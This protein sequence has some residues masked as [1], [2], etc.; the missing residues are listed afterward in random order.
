MVSGTDLFLSLFN[1]LAVFIVLI[2]VYGVINRHFGKSPSFTKQAAVGVCFGIFAIGCM[3]VKIPVAQGV[4]VDQRNA[5]V[6]LSGAFG[7]PF[8]AIISAV[9]AG[10][11][12]FQL[13]GMGVVGGIIGVFL[14]AGAGI[15]A[16][17]YRDKIDNIFKASLA[18]IIATVIILPGFL[19]IKDL[20]SGWELLQAMALPYGLAVFIGLL[21]VG[22]LLAHE[23]YRY[24]TEL[25]QKE[26]EKRYRE[27]FEN[28]I[29]V[30]YRI[31]S[32]GTVSLVSPSVEKVFGYS[33]EEMLGEKISKFL[34][35]P[36]RQAE[37][38]DLVK[39]EAQ[40]ANLEIEMTRKDGTPIWVSSNAK[41][42]TDNEGTVIGIE[43]ISRDIS[44]LKEAEFEKRVLETQLRQSQKMEAL[45]TLAGGIAHDFN[46]ILSAVIGFSEISLT[47]LE[48]DSPAHKNVKKILT[49][50]MRAR[51][52]VRQILTFSRKDERELIPL[53][54]EP[55]V[56]ETIKL[57]R[58]S[59][60]AT[61]EICHEIDPD[62]DNILADPTHIH[63]IVMNLCTNAAH[64][65]EEDGG[66]L[67]VSLVQ[68]RLTEHDIR[69]HP[70]LKP[71]E[72]L[73]LSVQDTGHGIPPEQIEKIYEP[74][75][76]TKD[77]DKGTGLGLAVVHGI[78][79]GY[80]GAIYAYSEPKIGTT[81]NVYLPTISKQ[82]ANG[83]ETVLDLPGGNE[84]IL[85]VDDE[86]AL[87]D[88][89][90]QM[91][92]HL[93]YR[94]N[95]AGGSMAAL[96]LFRQIHSEI[97]LVITDMTMPK[98][99]GE[100]LAIELL[101]IRPDIPIIINTG[102]S[103]ILSDEKLSTLGIKAMIHKPVIKAE[104]A[105]L[106]RDILDERDAKPR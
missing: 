87:V 37:F 12:R 93:G 22:L 46:N 17:F 61:I 10:T 59:I 27:L 88:A 39:R 25:E 102:Y 76:T 20:Q 32:E 38:I 96:N 33:P 68:V 6:A 99:N 81:F 43:G 8:A 74:Y 73:K 45:G 42:L 57:L 40:V 48:A 31:D 71:A 18:A 106:V 29:D 79:Q 105:R 24:L 91:L 1:N 49:A 28:L 66:Y 14:S 51:D 86:P 30:S 19:F 44:Q 70:G 54:V 9:F 41:S 77:T 34:K 60:P 36:A 67:K 5:V 4:I 100:K 104:L 80:G 55:L 23:E 98:M 94:V 97:D 92:E 21:F 3:H 2:A 35:D 15:I 53:Q 52:L 62:L 64:A 90:C 89:G 69:L 85:L 65:M 101:K 26:S 58:S 16:F 95:T 82:S 50:G 103:S 7:G 84:S 78:V 11:Y 72:Y 13:G 47:K 83:D 56:K 63:Q 75:Y